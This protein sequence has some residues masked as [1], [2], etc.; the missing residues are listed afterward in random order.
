MKRQEYN[1]E[2]IQEGETWDGIGPLG[3]TP[4]ISKKNYRFNRFQFNH[5]GVCINPICAIDYMGSGLKV[6]F[7]VEVAQTYE[8]RWC[9]GLWWREYITGRQAYHCVPC[10]ANHQSFDTQREAEIAALRVLERD[11]KFHPPTLEVVKEKIFDRYFVQQSL[12]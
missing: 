8:G 1:V 9:Y 2:I 3:T 10:T 5:H 6:T 11:L 7:C 12:F 4:A